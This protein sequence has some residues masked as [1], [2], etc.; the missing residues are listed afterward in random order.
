MRLFH[1]SIGYLSALFSVIGVGGTPITVGTLPHA[2]AIE[3]G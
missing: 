2:V 3:G 1:L